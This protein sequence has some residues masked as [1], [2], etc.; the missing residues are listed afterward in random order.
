MKK[1]DNSLQDAKHEA[2]NLEEEGRP[3]FKSKSQGLCGSTSW[4]GARCGSQESLGRAKT[5]YLLLARLVGCLTASLPTETD[6][7]T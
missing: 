7:K 4:K 3:P 1:L 6:G 2:V 5:F